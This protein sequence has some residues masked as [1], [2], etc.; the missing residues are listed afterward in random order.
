MRRQLHSGE[1]GCEAT[2]ACAVLSLPINS[3][4]VAAVQT[5]AGARCHETANLLSNYYLSADVYRRR[6]GRGD[7][8]AADAA[9]RTLKQAEVRLREFLTD[10]FDVSR[11]GCA[12]LAS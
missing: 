1:I 8:T 12:A 11:R 5:H 9:W 7:R 3:R 6:L 4:L 2:A 10:G